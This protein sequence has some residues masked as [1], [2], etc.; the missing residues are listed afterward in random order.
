MDMRAMPCEFCDTTQ[1]Q[2]GRV[3]T[4][5]C[6]RDGRWFIFEDV[7]AW[8]C[9]HCGHRYFDAEILSAVEFRMK[10]TPLDAR[11]I[12]VWAMSLAEKTI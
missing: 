9:P 11:P 5:A 7:L 10:T 2:E 8:V 3:V 1:P 4:V 12:T 6:Q